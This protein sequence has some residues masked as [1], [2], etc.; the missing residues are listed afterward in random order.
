MS[1]ESKSDNLFDPKLIDELIK[2]KTTQEELFGK[3]G[4]FKQ[5]QKAI[6]ERALEGEMTTELGYSKHDS[7]GDNSG[8]SRNGY[9]EKTLKSDAS[10]EFA[11]KVPRD[12]NGEFIPKIVPKH[13]TR[14]DGFDDK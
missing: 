12:R 7:V 5:L 1:K 3:N 10:G 4:V 13:Q 6:L 9:S 2:G 14:F 8:N 11:I